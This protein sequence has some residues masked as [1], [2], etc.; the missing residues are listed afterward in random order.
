M[1]VL[2]C[3]QEKLPEPSQIDEN[4]FLP[5][6]VLPPLIEIDITA[7]HIEQAACSLRGGAGPSGVCAMLWQSF[8]LRY[9]KHR[10]HMKEAVSALI[11]CIANTVVEWN[12]IRTL[13]AN[14]LI[15]LDKCP[16]VRPIGVG[17]CLHHVLGT[18]EHGYW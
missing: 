3:L 9:G 14:R 10:S 11:R 7:S 12:D 6:T 4:A 1:S 16:G 5:C 17:E 13:M 15:P 2:Q 8:L 18:H